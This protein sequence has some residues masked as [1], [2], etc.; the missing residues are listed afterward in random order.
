MRIIALAAGLLVI[1]ACTVNVYDYSTHSG[2]GDGSMP[3]DT[4]YVSNPSSGFAE[5]PPVVP[6]TVISKYPLLGGGHVLIEECGDW[7]S[8]TLFGCR[9]ETDGV[10]F[11]LR[12]VMVSTIASDGSAAKEFYLE[13][14]C[15][16]QAHMID[17]DTEN[18]LLDDGSAP[19]TSGRMAIPVVTGTELVTLVAHRTS[20]PFLA[21]EAMEYE[22]DWLADGTLLY[23]AV[24]NSSEWM[25]RDICTAE[26]LVVSSE[27]PDF[28]MIFGDTER[29]LLQQFFDI[30]VVHDGE[31]PVLP[32]GGGRSLD[33]GAGRSSN[34]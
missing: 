26:Q 22:G 25:V 20:F 30:F 11:D 34:R 33:R 31:P 3:P 12:P 2:G 9:T 16:I 8:Y 1:G 27:A 28:R 4:V 15:R 10:A 21:E 32:V 7:S 24:F 17:S 14:T 19:S 23:E 18:S 6:D 29:R 13:F 5:I